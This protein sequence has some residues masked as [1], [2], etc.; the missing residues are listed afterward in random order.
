[1]IPQMQAVMQAQ[2][3]ILIY[4][5]DVDTACN[6]IGDQMFVSQLNATVRVKQWISKIP[7]QTII[8]ELFM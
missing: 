2:K 8:D 7:S 1:M 5:G 4:S 3:P 6:T